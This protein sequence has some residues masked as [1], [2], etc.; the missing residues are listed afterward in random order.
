MGIETAIKNLKKNHFDVSRFETAR[1]AA[2]YID[3]QLDGR[4]VGIGGSVS[5][6]E[7]GLYDRLK[8]HNTVYWHMFDN[9]TD[10]T[11]LAACNAEVYITSANA[12]A[13][14]GELL[15]IDGR[16]NRLAGTLMQKD[17]VFIIVGQNKFAPDFSQALERAK[18][19]AAPQN[20]K[21]LEKKTPCAEG[22]KCYDCSAPDRICNA[23]LVLW[24]KPYWCRSME[25]VIVDEELGY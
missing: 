25:V 14:T 24:R 4:I 15:N 7:L 13:E 3:G 8:T 1:E 23:L 11:M 17:K 5:V 20:C 2:D 19:V 22:G 6:S 12:V 16:G 9:K 10:E 21:R 18:N